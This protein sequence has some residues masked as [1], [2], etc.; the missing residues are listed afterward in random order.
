MSIGAF[1]SRY[2][3]VNGVLMHA[4]YST[5]KSLNKSPALVMLHGLVVS[6][7]YMM[8]LAKQL[9]ASYPVILP[10][11]PGFGRSAKT[12]PLNVEQLA[13]S[14]D[15]WI[16]AV[17]MEDV[18]LI[19]NSFGCEVAAEY[20][21]HQPKELRLLVFIS[22]MR[23]QRL[24]ALQYLSRWALVTP[25]EP[26]SYYPVM[27]KDYLIAGAIRAAKTFKYGMEHMTEDAASQIRVPTLLVRG[28]RDVIVTKR[29][30]RSLES[31]LSSSRSVKIPRAAHALN[32]SHPLPLAYIIDGFIRNGGV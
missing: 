23:E 18:V 20:A 15:D 12:Q 8:P 6:N 26:I 14:L 27:A 2:D 5:N 11:M 13:R 4:Q 19:A 1:R 30:I 31:K 7:H 24:G 9:A 25:F 16:R 3:N 17:G 21:K 28:S 29:L 10:E 22:P 32:Y